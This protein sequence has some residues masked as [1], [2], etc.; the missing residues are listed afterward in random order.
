[1]TANEHIAKLAKLL[2]TL[3]DTIHTEQQLRH[4]LDQLNEELL[5]LDD[6][7]NT[8]WFTQISRHEGL[9]NTAPDETA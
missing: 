9:H 8:F 7:L 5:L 6:A 4:K 2:R 1:M 3:N